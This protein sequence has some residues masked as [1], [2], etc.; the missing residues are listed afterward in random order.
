MTADADAHWLNRV[1]L[2]D[3][4][5]VGVLYDRYCSVLLPVAI[6]IVGSHADGEDVVHD[7]FVTLP[8]RAIHYSADRGS[9]GAWL[10]ILVRN[11]SIDRIRRRGRRRVL[12]EENAQLGPPPGNSPPNPEQQA[13]LASKRD[14]VRSALAGLP[15]NHRSTLEM[16]FFEGL[17]Y[18]EIAEREGISLGTV[19]SRASRAIGA[20]REALARE[21]LTSDDLG[22]SR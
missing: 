1:A 17:T 6:R 22:A 10:T 13:V 15:T 19:K 7:A 3:L 8:E 16:S 5:A 18:S 21:G 2:G 12:D 4:E 20:L 14:R 11:L 9:V